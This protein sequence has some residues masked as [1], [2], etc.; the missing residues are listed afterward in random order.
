MSKPK[1]A[2]FENHENLDE[3][4]QYLDTETEMVEREQ[5]GERI[6]GN[7]VKEEFWRGKLHTLKQ[8]KGI[9]NRPE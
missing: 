7:V 9:L 5:A 6:G 4:I 1:T 3:L 8:C 2:S